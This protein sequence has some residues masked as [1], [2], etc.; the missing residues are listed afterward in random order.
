MNE[1]EVSQLEVVR[2]LR[3]AGVPDGPLERG[4]GIANEVWMTPDHVVRLNT[5]RFR[6]VFRFEADVLGRLPASIPHPA[7]IAVGQR[8]DAGEYLVLE[9]LPGRSLAETWPGLDTGQRRHLTHELTGM[10][11]ALH[12]IDLADWP[13]CPWVVDALAGI[14]ADAYHAPPSFA[15]A[16]VAAAREARPDA[17]ATL[18]QIA[19]FIDRRMD[20]FAG[21]TDVVVHTD[22]HIANVIV[23]GDRISGLIDFEGVR[24]APA[25][26]ELDM[27][28]RFVRSLAGQVDDIERLPGWFRQ[29][30]PEPFGHPRL[31]DRLEVYE[32]LWYLVQL[33]HWQPG[34]RWMDDPLTYLRDVLTGDFRTSIRE[35]LD[36]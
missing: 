26:V 36:A 29:V 11:R 4:G 14:W 31:L 9:R 6:D 3:A 22:L 13:P 23:D 18:D 2:I 30:Y 35:L 8:D 24:A 21:D 34:A 16:L 25:D 1:R 28:L 15:P 33:H 20:A 7:V 19:V 17:A 32:V 12:Q 5:G 27:L 10:I